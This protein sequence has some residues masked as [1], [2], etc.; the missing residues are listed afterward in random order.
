MYF[1]RQLVEVPRPPLKLE[2][3]GSQACHP[4]PRLGVAREGGHADWTGA[5][6]E[7]VAVAEVSP[8]GSELL[9]AVTTTTIVAPTSAAVSRK[10]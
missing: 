3:A 8:L 7:D 2:L 9:S 1:C 5:G 10:V 4:P 6:A